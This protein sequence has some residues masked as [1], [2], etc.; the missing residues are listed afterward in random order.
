MMSD[1]VF[2]PQPS[3]GYTNQKSAPNDW[4]ASPWTSIVRWRWLVVM[5]V[6]LMTITVEIVEHQT[7]ASGDPAFVGELLVFGMLLPVGAGWAL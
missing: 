1:P 5:L 4:L 6:A 7:V 2:S 3:A